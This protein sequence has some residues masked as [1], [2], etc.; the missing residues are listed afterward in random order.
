LPHGLLELVLMLLVVTALGAL[1]LRWFGD[2]HD[3]LA[4]SFVILSI[5]GFVLSLAGLFGRDGEERE[6]RWPQRVGGIAVLGLGI[7]LVL[8]LVL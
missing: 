1:L 3:F 6:M 4:D 5:P 7:L 2:S 8:G